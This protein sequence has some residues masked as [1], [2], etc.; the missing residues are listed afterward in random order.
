M[1]SY[2]K[3]EEHILKKGIQKLE[4][5]SESFKFLEKGEEL[6]TVNDIKEKYNEKR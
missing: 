6:Y 2:L 4:A 3:H 5:E 1:R